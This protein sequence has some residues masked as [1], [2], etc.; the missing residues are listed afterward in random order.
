MMDINEICSAIEALEHGSTTYDA[1]SKLAAL[2]TVRDHMAGDG[3]AKTAVSG[4]S[5]FLRSAA[6]KDSQTV[7]EIMDDLMA[8]L[9]VSMPKAY[10]SVMERVKGV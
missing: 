9:R 6:G 10:S 7:M 4:D 8:T 1:C 2:Y 3:I 5:D